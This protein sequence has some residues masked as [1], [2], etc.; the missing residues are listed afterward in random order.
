MAACV[1]ANT[2]QNC[3]SGYMKIVPSLQIA[4]SAKYTL[5]TFLKLPPECQDLYFLLLRARFLVDSSAPLARR[6]STRQ[7]R[8]TVSTVVG[9]KQK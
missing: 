2:V 4:Y 3:M 9:I 1:V 6:K 5:Q 7:N 8:D